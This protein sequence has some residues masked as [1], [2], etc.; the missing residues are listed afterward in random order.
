MPVVTEFDV[1]ESVAT[2][3]AAVDGFA[4]AFPGG[5]HPERKPAG[6]PR[7]YA[8]VRV[9]AADVLTDSSRRLVQKFG[10]EVTAWAATGASARTVRP[11]LDTL[12]GGVAEVPNAV[13]VLRAWPRPGALTLAPELRGGADVLVAS[14]RYWL[15]LEADRGT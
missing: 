3:A 6:K 11:L 9:E 4:D 13:R 8:V 7:P 1:H 15:L 14:C 10:V 12:L 5:L 2:R